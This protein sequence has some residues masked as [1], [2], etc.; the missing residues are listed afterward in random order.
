MTTKQVIFTE[1][2]LLA[3]P[4]YAEPLVADGVRCHG[5]FDDDGEYRS[6]RT[7]FRVPAIEAWDEQ[8]LEQFG[9]PKLDIGVE[10]WPEHFPNV[11]QTRF[12][13]DHGAPDSVI[14]ELTRIGTVEGF[15]SLLRYSPM[16]DLP[17]CFE[18]DI[19]GTA[20]DHLNGGLY[21]AHARDEAGFE[22]VAGHKDM[23]FIARDLAFDHPVTE[24]QTTVMLERMGIPATNP[25]ELAKI[26][27]GAEAARLLPSVIDF[28]L[29]SLVAR[30]VNLLF[31]EVTA[32]H[33]FAWAEEILGDTSRVAGEGQAADLVRY[34]RADETPHV[35]Y[36]GTVLSEMRDRT[37]VG[38]DGS[39]HAGEEMIS[40]L[41]DAILERS[42]NESRQQFLQT[43]VAEIRRSLDGCPDAGDLW[44]EFLTLGAVV[45]REDG[46]Y[47]DAT[48]RRRQP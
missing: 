6:P 1:A 15:G 42:I 9:S 7:R 4:V 46:T 24:D 13:L 16:P 22:D 5:G 2:E 41:W 34:I 23:W 48:D 14:S 27:A 32:F 12:L 29:E 47:F 37:W 10:T 31:I 11:T 8:R 28:E 18:E 25:A 3:D 17:T 43:I 35:G 36:L 33:A 26:R 20:I 30:M 21:E 40:T 39:R 19:Q 45:R 44:E 38:T